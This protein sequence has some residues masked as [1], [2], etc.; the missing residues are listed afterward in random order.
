[1]WLRGSLSVTFNPETQAKAIWLLFRKIF[2]LLTSR[3]NDCMF[4]FILFF[5]YFLAKLNNLL[6]HTP[7]TIINNK[8]TA[9][10]SLTLSRL[11]QLA[12]MCVFFFLFFFFWI[13]I[14]NL[15]PIIKTFFFSPSDLSDKISLRKSLPTP[16]LT[17]L[18][19]PTCKYTKP[20]FCFNYY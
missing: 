7:R 8:L 15:R 4:F 13:K 3:F 12:Y 16:L 5:I 18:C 17:R 20:F 14:W 6:A 2:L 1:M 11:S 9:V 10:P 19:C